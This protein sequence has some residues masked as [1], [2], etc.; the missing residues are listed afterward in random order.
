MFK[1][2][3][4]GMKQENRVMSGVDSTNFFIA[5]I[6]SQLRKKFHLIENVRV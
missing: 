1:D 6:K 3:L 4:D 2:N 5:V